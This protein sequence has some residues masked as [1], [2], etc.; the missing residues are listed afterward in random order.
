MNQSTTELYVS[1]TT[2]YD[3]G[4]DYDHPT[5][6]PEPDS[7]PTTIA[8][9]W[10]ALVLYFLVFILGVP[11]NGLVVWITAF[12]MK[13]SVN[14]IWFLNLAVAD[15]LCCLSVPFTIMNISLGYWPLGLFTCKF[16]PS[17]L[18]ITMY[19][20]V[21]LLTMISIDRCALVMKPVWCQN[22]RTL[23][24]AYLACA[25]MW[26]L[27]IIQSSPSFIFR[28]FN[29]SDG[30]DYCIYDYKILKQE[31]QQRV[32]NFIAIIRLLMGFIVPFLVIVT[33]YGILMNRVK[34]RFTQNTKTMKVVLTVIA[35][36][37]VCWLPYHVAGSI[38]ALHPSNSELYQSTK[39]VDKIII[40][41]AFMNS[42]INPIIYVLMGQDFKSKFR[43]SIKFI[44]KNVLAEEVSQSLDSKKTKST[45]ETKHTEAYV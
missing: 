45:S 43:K 30:K 12:E 40:A 32:E 1:I 36:F 20:S 8:Y 5:P 22:N 33:C 39:K 4:E 29:T 42:C 31:N 18:L 21:L 24:K 6:E 2:A 13:R 41:I 10:I 14:T 19:A 25:I 16:I 17:I 3:Y 38:L 37:F 28:H 35:G 23:G 34:Q 26:I 44:L 9:K 7:D 27:A 15:L 11:G